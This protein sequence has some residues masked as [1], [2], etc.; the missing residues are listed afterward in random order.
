MTVLAGGGGG[1]K[2]GMR[3]RTGLVVGLAVGY[4]FGTRAGRERYEQIEQWLGR[5]RTVADGGTARIKLSDGVREGT[6]AAWRL[7]QRWSAGPAD[8]PPPG[9]R[10]PT[11]ATASPAYGDP[12][13]N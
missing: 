2:G 3:F 10:R 1:T 7:V 11:P 5:V 4:Y 13:M 8:G 12:T 9:G 6:V